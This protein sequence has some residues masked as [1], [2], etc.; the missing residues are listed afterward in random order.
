MAVYLGV[1]EAEV[2]EAHLAGQAFQV[3]YLDTPL[4]QDDDPGVSTSDLIGAD[5]SQLEQLLDMD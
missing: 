5:D 3:A 4:R 2:A 1:S